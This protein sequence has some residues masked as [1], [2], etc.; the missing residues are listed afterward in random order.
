MIRALRNSS[1]CSGIFPAVALLALLIR[2]LIPAGFMP[3]E[4][5]G[6]LTVQ[7]CSGYGPAFVEIDLGKKAPADPH[8]PSKSPCAFSGGFTG[9]LP[10]FKLWSFTGPAVFGVAVPVLLAVADRTIRRLA[11]PPPPAIGPPFPN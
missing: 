6:K 2:L 8:G 1:H 4:S 3:V 10:P 11:A 5:G 7:L 9:G